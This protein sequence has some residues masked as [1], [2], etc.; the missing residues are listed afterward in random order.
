MN[1]Q[2]NTSPARLSG[3]EAAMRSLVLPQMIRKP[4]P[5]SQRR[6]RT[7]FLFTA[8]WLLGFILLTIFPLAFGLFISL[9]NYD[10]LNLNNLNFVGIRNY[11]TAFQDPNVQLTFDRTLVWTALNLPTWLILSLLLAVIANQKVKGI[12]VFRTLFYLPSIIPAVGLVWTWKILLEKNYG[13][14]N[15]II[16]I[17]RPGTAI[18]WL[19]DQAMFGVTAMALWNGLGAG[20]I[21]FLA[22]LQGVPDELVEAAKIDGAGSFRV[23]WHITLPMMTPVIFYQL[24]M[25]LISAFQQLTIPWLATTSPG[26]I[27]VPPRSIYLYMINVYQQIFGV[28]RFGYGMA[29]LWLLIVVILILTFLVFRSQRYWVY[30]EAEEK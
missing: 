9:T 20:M 5:R 15:A 10:G 2:G 22:G 26:V 12:G 23:F 28:G 7:F 11:Q 6:T 16:S 17:W 4:I 30:S 19:T 25:G 13:L 18:G 24:V 3:M 21:I 14:L 29:M 27:G 1:G 8:P